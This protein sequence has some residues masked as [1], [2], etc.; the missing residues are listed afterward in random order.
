MRQLYYYWFSPNSRKIQMAMLEKELDFEL[1]LELPWKRRYEFLVLNP[2]GTVPFLIEDD[3]ST[4]CGNYTLSEYLDEKYQSRNLTGTDIQTR[5]EVRRLTEWFDIKFYEEVS[6]LVINEKFMKRYLKRGDTE[7]AV[8][9]FANHNIKHHLQYITYLSD[10]KN[11][12]AGNDFSFA[13]IAAA[14]HLSCV[15]YFGDVPWDKFPKAKDW[16]A[17]VKSRP[18]MQPILKDKVAGLQPAIYYSNPD[19]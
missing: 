13:D 6:Q 17:R 9:R 16:Y 1:V 15:D 5:A 2:A 7:A 19:F 4:I 10:R 18:S 12:L 11:W 14:S 3:G 8:I